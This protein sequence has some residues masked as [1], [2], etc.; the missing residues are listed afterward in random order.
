MSVA[1]RAE[2]PADVAIELA[3]GALAGITGMVRYASEFAAL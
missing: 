1:T 2:L 3:P